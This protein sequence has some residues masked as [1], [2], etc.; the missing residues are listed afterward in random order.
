MRN[1]VWSQVE[2][3]QVALVVRE[4]LGGDLAQIH[5]MSSD[6]LTQIVADAQRAALTFDRRKQMVGLWRM[7]GDR[8]SRFRER[9]VKALYEPEPK[10]K[11]QAPAEQP[12]P[13]FANVTLAQ[14][15]ALIQQGVLQ[16]LEAYFHKPP[17]TFNGLDELMGT[18]SH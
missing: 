7:C 6:E 14:L 5:Q 1:T 3:K 13:T 8:H 4:R 11:P 15:Q 9:L 12:E 18:S 17:S 10:A 2:L 16:G